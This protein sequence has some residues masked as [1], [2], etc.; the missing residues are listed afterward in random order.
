MALD[1]SALV[2]ALK[3]GFQKGLDD[4]DWDQDKAA[5]ELADAIDAYVR[6]AEVVGIQVAVVDLAAAP[7]G[8]GTQLG[9][10]SLE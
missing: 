7:L 1:K 4:P 6:G 3:S 2:V 10:G 8:T 9:K 5:K